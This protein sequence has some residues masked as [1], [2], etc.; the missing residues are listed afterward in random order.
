MPQKAKSM[1][2]AKM[3]NM[4]AP[5]VKAHAEDE[6]D[7]GFQKLPPGITNGVAQLTEAYFDEYKSGDNKGQFYFRA[8][9]VVVSPNEIE[10]S[11]GVV[12]VRRLQTSLME[13]MCQTKTQDGKVTTVEEHV[14]N[15]L[16][17]LRKLG[18][19][20]STATNGHDLE[21]ICADLVEFKPYFKFATSVRKAR[22]ANQ[23][24][25]VWENWYGIKGLEDFVPP[26][27]DDTS[28]DDTGV[29]VGVGHTG[30]EAGVTTAGG[31]PNEGTDEWPG[32]DDVDALGA[33]ADAVP[34]DKTAA[35]KLKAIA[36]GIGITET[37][38]DDVESWT[39]LAEMIKTGGAVAPVGEEPTPE[40]VWTPTKGATCYVQVW[41]KATKKYDTSVECEIMTDPKD[42][43]VTLKDL[44]TGKYL[45]DPK[46]NKPI[47]LVAVDKIQ[48]IPF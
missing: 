38:V 12:T 17:E 8:V 11:Q 22:K 7:Y 29:G 28:S 40:K 43:K 30:A 25:G 42:G 45:I 19:D 10:T 24:D 20:T 32:H 1:F 33:A 27:F 48:P 26:D 44:K 35:A 21:K 34:P 6:T 31:I 18:A 39:I 23:A 47:G 9:G 5:A 37:Q 16:N 15:V 36:L 41:N 4:I 46:T 13:P 2:A 14:A 3:A